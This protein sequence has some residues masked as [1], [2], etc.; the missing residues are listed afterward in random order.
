[1]D[2]VPLE[3]VSPRKMTDI[4]AWTD[5]GYKNGQAPIGLKIVPYQA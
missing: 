5:A 4:F 3:F 1:M 2:S